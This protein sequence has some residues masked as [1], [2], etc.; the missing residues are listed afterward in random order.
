MRT[1]VGADH[2][3]FELKQ[4]MAGHLCHPGHQVPRRSIIQILP[5]PSAK[6]E[7]GVGEILK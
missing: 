3:D 5:K 1:V 4:T 7:R 6:R 2:A